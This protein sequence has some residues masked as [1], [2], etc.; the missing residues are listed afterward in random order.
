MTSHIVSHHTTPHQTAGTGKEQEPVHQSVSQPGSRIADGITP[1]YT[2][3]SRNREGVSQSI[4]PPVSQ[5]HCQWQSHQIT[6][7]IRNREV[8]KSFCRNCHN[9]HSVGKRTEKKQVG[10]RARSGRISCTHTQTASQNTH[11]YKHQCSETHTAVTRRKK[12]AKR[13]F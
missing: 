7:N 13:S 3:N 12:N 1:H 10:P 2:R 11:T 9:I 5:P 8:S 6:S 4:S